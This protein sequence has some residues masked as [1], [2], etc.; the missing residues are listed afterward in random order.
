MLA[1]LLERLAS[2]RPPDAEAVV[3]APLRSLTTS[4]VRT[5]FFAA[6]VPNEQ[7]I[8][9]PVLAHLPVPA[10]TLVMLEALGRVIFSFTELSATRPRLLS[11]TTSESACQLPLWRDAVLAK[12]TFK[13]GFNFAI[14]V[15]CRVVEAEPPAP[16]AARVTV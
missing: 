12:L 1:L 7:M 11:V 10:E 16:V 5:V 4:R 14:T 15:M 9:C 13:S 2:A 8:R 6:I 3:L